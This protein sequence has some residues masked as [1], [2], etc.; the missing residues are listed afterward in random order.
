MRATHSPGLSYAVVGRDGPLHQRTWGDRRTRR[1][2]HPAHTLPVGLYRQARHGDRRHDARP[3]RAAAPGRPRHR[4]SARFPVRRPGSRRQGDDPPP[5]GAD[6]RDPRVGHVQGH[7]LPRFRLPRGR[8]TSRRS[9]RRRTTGPSGHEV[10]LHQRELPGPHRRGRVGHR[11]PLRRPPEAGRVRPGGHGRHRRRRGIRQEAEA[12]AGAPV[13]LGRPRGD[14]RRIRRARRRLRVPGRRP[15]RPGRL[16]V[17]PAPGGLARPD[18]RVGAPHA[19][20]GPCPR[21]RRDGLRAGLAGRRAGRAA[22]HGRLAHG[23]DSRLLGDA[24]PASAAERRPRPAAE[25]V[26]AHAGRGDHAGRVRC[27]ADARR[28]GAGRRP[29]R[30]RIPPGH[31]GPHRGGPRRWSWRPAGRSC[32]CAVPP[33]RRLAS[34]RPPRGRWSARLPCSPSWPWVVWDNC[35]RC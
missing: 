24:V 9:G 11:A 28:R 1:A 18:R 34:R 3:V 21:R 19:P 23:G 12:A 13:L 25:R 6:R 8:R 35:V 29:V 4:P 26:R 31:L 20:G 27:R 7:R 32:S 14:R 10:R 33:R 2:R 30:V 17:P 5:T 15:R 22:R 16:R